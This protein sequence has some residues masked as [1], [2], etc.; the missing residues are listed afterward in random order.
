ML[1]AVVYNSETGYTEQYAQI[2]AKKLN[3]PCYDLKSEK[4]K[5]ERKDKIIYLGWI[6]AGKITGLNKVK[7][8]YDVVCYA[9]VGAFPE[10]DSYISSLV[11]GNMLEE[12]KFFYLRGGIN[13]KKLKG[14]K[15]LIVKMVGKV[16]EK[17]EKNN[18]ELI[19]IFNEGASFVDANNLEKMLNYI[20]KV[21]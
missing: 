4:G 3:I 10:D 11:T 7:K 2:L 21:K 1:N 8:K 13:F 17:N 9:G 18:Q 12:E 5:L 16:L 19:R 20:N 15:K 14:Y 6:C